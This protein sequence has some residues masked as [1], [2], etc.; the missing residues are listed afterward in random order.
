M[1]RSVNYVLCTSGRR[2]RDE[3]RGRRVRVI[4]VDVEG[5][6]ITGRGEKPENG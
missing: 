3:G 4:G 2:G 1:K 5:T 6:K